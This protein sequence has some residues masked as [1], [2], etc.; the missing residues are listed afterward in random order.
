M[1]DKITSAELKILSVFI[2]HPDEPIYEQTFNS[3]Y[4]KNSLERIS[5]VGLCD[6]GFLKMHS[7]DDQHKNNYFTI[8][9]DGRIAYKQYIDNKRFSTLKYILS[10]I[11]IP[12]IIGISSAVISAIIIS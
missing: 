7:A 1:S 5:A 9:R 3:L 6:N 10:N 4:P 12:L 2:E 11:I 8:E